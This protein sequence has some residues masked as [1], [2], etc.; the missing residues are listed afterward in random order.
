MWKWVCWGFRWGRRMQLERSQHS[1]SAGLLLSYCREI[2]SLEATTSLGSNVSGDILQGFILKAPSF[3]P[4]E[5]WLSEVMLGWVFLFSL[6]LSNALIFKSFYSKSFKQKVKYVEGKVVKMFNKWKKKIKCSWKMKNIPVLFRICTEFS[7][8]KDSSG[9]I[10]VLLGWGQKS[11][12]GVL[13]FWVKKRK[14]RVLLLPYIRIMTSKWKEL[15]W[16]T[17]AFQQH[18]P[19]TLQTLYNQLWHGLAIIPWEMRQQVYGC[20]PGDTSRKHR[21]Q[22]LAKKATCK[23][24]IQ[25]WKEGLG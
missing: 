13:I 3:S 21:M 23:I 14:N 16:K 5:V 22:G 8:P 6:P 7:V 4:T 1:T 15:C 20:L 18:T 2:I 25:A 19:F 11:V 12:C 9:A 10:F 24:Q 17:K